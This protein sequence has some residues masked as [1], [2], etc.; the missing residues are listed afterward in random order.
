MLLWASGGAVLGDLARLAWLSVRERAG[1]A[2]L[3]AFGVFI[4]FLALS[5]ALSIGESFKQAVEQAFQQLGLNT[6]WVIAGS[7]ALT[8][9]D[10][11]AASAALGGRAVVIPFGASRGGSG[12]R[13]AASGALRCF[14]CRRSM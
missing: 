8:D 9:V 2:A 3:A 1:R 6:V 4:A 7:T 11:A 5:A 12:F 14:T 13:M 10:V